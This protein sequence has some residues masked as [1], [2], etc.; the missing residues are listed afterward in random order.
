MGFKKNRLSVQRDEI[1]LIY[2]GIERYRMLRISTSEKKQ[3]K[4]TTETE[5]MEYKV[6]FN[7]GVIVRGQASRQ[8]HRVNCMRLQVY[9]FSNIP[10]YDKGIFYFYDMNFK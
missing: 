6:Y 2:L 3:R 1:C 9:A 8:H 7:N 10:M 5:K 4:R